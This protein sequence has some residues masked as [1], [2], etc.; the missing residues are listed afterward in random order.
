VRWPF[1][2]PARVPGDV[3]A[4]A[5]LSRS[6]RVLA[7]AAAGDGTWLLGTRAA[8]VVLRPDAPVETVPWERVETADWDRDEERLRVRGVTA[9]DGSQPVLEVTLADPGRLLQLVR[10]RVTASVLLQRRALLPGS[11]A[12][13]TVVGRRSPVRTGQVTWTV[14]HDAGLDPADPAVAELA[15]GALRAAQDE[16]GSI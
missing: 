2:R 8:L 1:R 3:L 13:V 15:A 7:H 4:R 12:G 9:P 16:V 6:D 10:E 11:Q 5:G 14:E